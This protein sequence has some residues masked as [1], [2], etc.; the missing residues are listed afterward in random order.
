MA[1]A[2][3]SGLYVII[4]PDACRGRDVL[5]VAERA[6]EGGASMLQWRDKRREKGAQLSEA[7]ALRELCAEH[8]ALLIV[9]DHAD[10]ALAAG[11]DGVH[12]GQGDLPVEEVRRIVPAGFIVG[13]ST[14]NVH[15]ALAAEA[16]GAS[17]IAIGSIYPTS[18]KE[19][20]RTRAA[21]PERLSEVKAAVGVPVIAIGGIDASNIEEVVRA[22][23]DAVAV[24]SAVCGADD[25]QAAAR[26]LVERQG[27]GSAL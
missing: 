4:D 19:P 26:E 25:P 21:S 9:N 6:L 16:A 11:A 20:E 10:L 8:G 18:S 17:Y 14:N 5:D 2:K 3:I 12:V 13:A 7:R 1:D 22:G 27:R 15:E 24:I 23:A